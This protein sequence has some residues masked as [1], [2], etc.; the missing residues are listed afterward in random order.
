[1]SSYPRQAS[2]YPLLDQPEDRDSE[3]FVTKN[4]LKMPFSN[5]SSS[6]FVWDPCG[7]VCA[8]VTY[9]LIVYGEF[10][11]LLVLAPP[12][13]TIG[14]GINVFIFTTL[15]FLAVVSHVKAMCTDPVSFFPS[16]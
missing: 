8:V 13:P 12:F 7:I 9:M 14:T 3:E 4:T 11:V 10:V 15:A 16:L 1:M 2:S 6:W 5:S